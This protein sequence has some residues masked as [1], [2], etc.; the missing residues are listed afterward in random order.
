MGSGRLRLA[1]SMPHP[2]RSRH[3]A[4]PTHPPALRPQAAWA[5]RAYVPAARRADLAAKRRWLAAEADLGR[6]AITER[7]LTTFL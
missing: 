5:P 2:L 3:P 6:V 1:G 4:P 7:E